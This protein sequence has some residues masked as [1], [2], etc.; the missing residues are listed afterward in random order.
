MLEVILLVFAGAQAVGMQTCW[1]NREDKTT[2]EE[3]D[4]KPDYMFSSLE[5]L[6]NNLVSLAKN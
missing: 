1:I 4:L 6:T 2:N 3:L 5:D